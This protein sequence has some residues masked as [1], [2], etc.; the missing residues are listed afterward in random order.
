MKNQIKAVV[1]AI[2]THNPGEHVYSDVLEL[3]ADVA[4][5]FDND[6]N[7]DFDGRGYR[8]I[9]NDDILDIMKD[10]LASDTYFLG[11]GSDWFMSDVTGI[12]VDAIRKIQDAN[13]FEALGII[14]ANKDEMLTAFADGIISHDGAGHHFSI[15]DFSETE[16][17]EYTVFCVN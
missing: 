3:F 9:H 13:A 17:G 10:E 12:P 4:N 8:V 16:A 11:C 15:Y 5:N 14:I 2:L 1:N 6:F 7:V